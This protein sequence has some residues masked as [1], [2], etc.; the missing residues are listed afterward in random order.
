VLVWRP[1]G[2]SP[3]RDDTTKGK[4][5]GG[6][7][8]RERW[9]GRALGGLAHLQ[10]SAAPDVGPS[11]RVVVVWH[12]PPLRRVHPLPVVLDLGF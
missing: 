8:K 3:L 6:R 4:E 11:E 7:G 2:L 5:D 1:V 12:H 9:Q 10:A